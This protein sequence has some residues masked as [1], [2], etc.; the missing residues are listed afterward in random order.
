MGSSMRPIFWKEFMRCAARNRKARARWRPR[1]N[2]RH[3]RPRCETPPRAAPRVSM[4]NSRCHAPGRA[5]ITSHPL[6]QIDRLEHRMGDEDDGLVQLAP[7]LEQIV[8]EPKA[9]DLVERRERLVQQQ[10]IRVG[11]ERARQRDPHLHAAGQ[12][13]RDMHRQIRQDRPAP[14]PPRCGRRHRPPAHAQVSAA[15]ERFRAR[16]PT[17][18]ASAPETQSRWDAAHPLRRRDGK[19]SPCLNS[20]R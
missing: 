9:R 3:I 15:G 16:S 2:R 20:A 8:V 10:N 13:A 12:F 5:V 6:R 14:A 11:D 1:G 17:A 4:R 19:R 7:Q 18:S